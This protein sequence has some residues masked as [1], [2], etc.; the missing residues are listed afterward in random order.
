MKPLPIAL[1][2][3]AVGLGVWFWSSRGHNTDGPQ[4]RPSGGDH[5]QQP[6]PKNGEGRRLLDKNARN[7]TKAPPPDTAAAVKIPPKKRPPS[8]KDEPYI[9]VEGLETQL[10]DDALTKELEIPNHPQ[11]GKGILV[12]KVSPTSPAAE[13][14]LRPKDVIVIAD[15]KP[16][17]SMDDLREAVK[18]RTHTLVVFSRDGALHQVVIKPPYRG[19]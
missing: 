1:L 9:A 4:D 17:N 16:V 2:A 13:A 5:T 11:T 14:A 6:P 18:G 7:K 3:G 8:V 12:T 15:K 10:M 19:E